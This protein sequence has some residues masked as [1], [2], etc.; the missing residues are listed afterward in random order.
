MNAQV[1]RGQGGEQKGRVAQQPPTCPKCV[2]TAASSSKLNFDALRSCR[3]LSLW[4]RT[5]S[6]VWSSN[7][8]SPSPRRRSMNTDAFLELI[9]S[10]RSVASRRSTALLRDAA[11]FRFP[12]RV[13]RFMTSC[14]NLLFPTV[15]KGLLTRGLAAAVP[16]VPRFSAAC[17]RLRD[18]R[19]LPILREST[20]SH[21]PPPRPLKQLAL[22]N[23]RRGTH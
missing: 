15:S 10:F 12:P 16:L 22:R 1:T 23:Y 7:V 3:F 6:L 5:S 9:H 18:V 17:C 4:K 19:F 11:T 14:F 13:R 20:P 2:S 8:G 21:Q